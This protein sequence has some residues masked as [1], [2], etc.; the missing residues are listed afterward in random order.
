MKKYL[1][2]MLFVVTF[3]LCGA[4]GASAAE[5]DTIKVGLKY[6]SGALYSANLLNEEG[7]GYEFGWFDSDREFQYLGS[8][9]ETAISMTAAG[10]IAVGSDGA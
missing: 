1:I 10:N 4:A 9:R 3:F 7:E 2:T 5:K 8:T 6:G